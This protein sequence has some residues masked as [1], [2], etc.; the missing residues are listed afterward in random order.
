[1]NL[2]RILFMG[3]PDYAANYLSELIQAEKKPFAVITQPDR[4][5]GRNK[6]IEPTPV[7]TIAI[8]NGIEVFQ[9]TDIRDP[10]WSEK[11]R[12]LTPDIIVVVAFGQIIP[13][14]ILE[15]PLKGC[16]NVHPSLLPKY[17]GASPLQATILNGDTDTGVTIIRMDEK[18][19]HGPILAQE[20]I[21]LDTRE[22]IQSLRKKTTIIGVRLLLTVLKQIESDAINSKEQNHSQ[23]TYTKLLKLEDGK[24]DF[25][26]E[27]ADQIDRKIRALNP[28]PGTW[29]MLQGKRLKILEAHP[30]SNN[31]SSSAKKGL[32]ISCDEN[33]KNLFAQCASGILQIDTVHLEGKKPMSGIEFIRGNIKLLQ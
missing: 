5:T 14:S 16:I 15:I 10:E 19:D 17:R 8:K 23:A 3:T 24:I 22:T 6:R 12:K 18:M 13:K 29:V 7:K 33:Q 27:S 1:M 26:E 32:F 2:Q 9:P 4:P 31:D 21:R 30:L 11:I 28:E 25:T 20:T